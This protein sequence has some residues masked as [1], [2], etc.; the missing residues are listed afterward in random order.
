MIA[1]SG[2]R[3]NRPGIL[4]YSPNGAASS[5]FQGGTLCIAPQGLRR[6]PQVLSIGGSGGVAC[7]AMF[8]IDWAAF[9]S[10]NLGGTPQ[11]YLNSIGTRVNVQWWGRD[12]TVV[13]SFL[14]NAIQYEVCP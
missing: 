6:G 9:A 5:P 13:G 12:S 7:D 10:G 4:I 11:S 8:S 1:A 14:S 2:A 3:A